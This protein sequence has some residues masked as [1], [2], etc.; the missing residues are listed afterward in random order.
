MD[1]SETQPNSEPELQRGADRG[2]DKIDRRILRVLQTDGRITNQDLAGQV[3]QDIGTSDWL[4]VD[5]AR[6]DRFAEADWLEWEGLPVLADAKA[7]FACTLYA[8]HDGG[9]HARPGDE[10]VAEGGAAWGGH[11]VRQQR[12]DE[13]LVAPRGRREV[14]RHPVRRPRAERH[15]SGDANGCDP[16][17]A[18]A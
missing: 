3:G 4:Q 14:E 5:Q 16:G 13:E 9:D 1:A 10:R 17:A 7:A 2:L 8:D 11:R 15:R 6:I 18:S 12:A